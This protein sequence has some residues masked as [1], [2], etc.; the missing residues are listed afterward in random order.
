MKINLRGLLLATK[1]QLS[2]VDSINGLRKNCGQNSEDFIDGI[3]VSR[4][5]DLIDRKIEFKYV[6]SILDQVL[7][8]L[9]LLAKK[10]ELLNQ[11]ADI[12]CLVKLD[13]SVFDYED[14]LHG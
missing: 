9:A 8:H 6:S 7:D 2:I 13:E 12:Y 4:I 1:R 10:P 11:F 14:E 5:K 3:E